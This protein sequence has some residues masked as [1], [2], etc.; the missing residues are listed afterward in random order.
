MPQD[1]IDAGEDIETAAL[2]ELHEETG[3]GK[4]VEVMKIAD[5]KTRYDLPEHLSSTLW[6]GRY[7]GQEQAWVAMRFTGQDHDIRLDRFDPPE[8]SAWQ[9]IEFESILSFAVPFK[10]ETYKQ[11]IRLFEDLI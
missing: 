5:K 7:K 8:F 3:V 6:D 4:H 9:W 2:R 11:V 10:K 1:G